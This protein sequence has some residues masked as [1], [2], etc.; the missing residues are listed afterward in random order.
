MSKHTTS[1][2]S[3]EKK[4][5]ESNTREKQV[6]QG[7]I[8]KATRLGFEDIE[9]ITAAFRSSVEAVV[10]D[11]FF[12]KKHIKKVVAKAIAILKS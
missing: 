3:W 2:L 9:E 8:V 4:N 12:M 10:L 1:S 6:L 11:E 7:L 5:K